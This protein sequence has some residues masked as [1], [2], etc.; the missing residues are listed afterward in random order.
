MLATPKT[1]NYFSVF[2]NVISPASRGTIKLQSTDPF[3]APL[4]DPQLLGSPVDVAIIVESIKKARAFLAAKAWNGY[5]LA[6]YGDYAKANT[7]AEI[8]TYARQYATTVWHPVGT[9]AIA[10][11]G[12]KGGVVNSDLT[13]KGTVGL[14]V[15]DASVLVRSLSQIPCAEYADADALLFPQPY[16]PSA[17]TQIP[18]YVVAER[19]ADL[20]KAA[21]ATRRY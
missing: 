19:A 16:I 4:I 7:D 13:V 9:A 2:T 5:I 18:V 1:G 14:R 10:S 21:H 8:E 15:V 12:S 3:T 11:K 20:I 6:P 17:H